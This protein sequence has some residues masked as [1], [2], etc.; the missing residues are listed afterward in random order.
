MTGFEPRTSGN[1]SDRSTNWATTTAL[2][3][4]IIYSSHSWGLGRQIM[5]LVYENQCDQIW[6]NSAT[7]KRLQ[8]LCIF[9]KSLSSI[10]QNFEL[11][12]EKFVC[13]WANLFFCK[14]PTID[15]QSGHTEPMNL[16]HKICFYN[17]RAKIY[18]FYS[19]VKMSTHKSPLSAPVPLENWTEWCQ[20]TSGINAV[21]ASSLYAANLLWTATDGCVFAGRAEIF[22]LCNIAVHCD[23]FSD[24]R[25]VWTSFK[26]L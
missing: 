7:L 4:L 8:I 9:P 13:Y 11:I 1:G 15:K 12:L 2:Q 20:Q 24:R 6:R 19:V 21:K 17:E 26:T 22:Y 5:G 18:G 3:F 23:S 14:W 10:W 16:S 25:L